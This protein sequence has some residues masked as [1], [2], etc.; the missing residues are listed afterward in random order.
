MPLKGMNPGMLDERV[1]IWCATDTI[2]ADHSSTESFA[3]TETVWAHLIFRARRQVERIMSG[4]ETAL[5][6][7]S[8]VIRKLET[9]TLTTKD[10]VRYDGDSFDVIAI[11]KDLGRRQYWEIVTELKT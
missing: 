5:Q 7:V 2:N 4:K 10:Q 11:M 1:E 8:F 6:Q 9:F 3:L